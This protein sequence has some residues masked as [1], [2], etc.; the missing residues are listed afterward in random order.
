MTEKDGAG[1]T[2]AHS[3][4]RVV[5]K[6]L[7]RVTEIATVILFCAFTVVVLM[8]V[9]FR[10]V[11]NESIIWSEEFVR[12]SLFWTVL[13]GAGLVTLDNTHL[14]IDLIHR[15]LRPA[16]QRIVQNLVHTISFVF[17]AILFWHGISLVRRSITTSPALGFPMRWVYLAMVVGAALIMIF[18]LFVAIRGQAAGGEEGE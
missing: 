16:G 12:F 11:I 17:A 7:R 2:S 5:I 9:F 15:Y 14:R 8:A 18:T 10:F 6:W 1:G 3:I 13:L 4:D